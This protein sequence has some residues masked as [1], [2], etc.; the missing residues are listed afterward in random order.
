MSTRSDNDSGM[1]ML[2]LLFDLARSTWQVDNAFSEVHCKVQTHARRGLIHRQGV[3]RFPD[4]SHHYTQFMKFLDNLIVM[5]IK[6]VR[7]KDCIE[8]VVTHTIIGLR[9]KMESVFMGKG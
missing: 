1:I 2:Q 7:Q 4:R 5:L 9:E 3:H 6:F 8:P